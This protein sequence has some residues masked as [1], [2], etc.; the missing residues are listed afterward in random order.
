MAKIGLGIRSV[1]EA[2]EMFKLG[3]H[4]E[5][6]NEETISPRRIN[7]VLKVL[8]RRIDFTSVVNNPAG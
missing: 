2:S 3:L 1:G 6:T 8:T 5:A 7:L 4:E